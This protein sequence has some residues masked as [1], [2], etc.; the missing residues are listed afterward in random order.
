MVGGLAV[1]HHTGMPWRVTRDLDLAISIQIEDFPGPL[2]GREGWES[3]PGGREHRKVFEG[4]LPVD[5]LPVGS[6]LGRKGTIT[7]PVSHQSMTVVG[8]ELAFEYQS[9]IAIGVDTRV[10]V[11]D[12]CVVML[13]KMVAFSDNPADRGRDL[14]DILSVLVWDEDAARERLFDDRIVELDLQADEAA[15]FLIGEDVGALS[16]ETCL[17][18]IEEF[19]AAADGGYLGLLVMSSGLDSDTVHRLWAALKS[20]IRAARR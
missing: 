9:E 12:L 13:L 1:A 14:H 16:D 5:F 15:A 10:R 20:G 2:S 3:D 4:C 11:A 8:V 7:W 19:F 18:K 17:G 6:A